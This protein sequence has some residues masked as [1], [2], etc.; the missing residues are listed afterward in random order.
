MCVMNVCQQ[1]VL[2]IVNGSG[3][4]VTHWSLQQ[5]F[6]QDWCPSKEPHLRAIKHLQIKLY[7]LLSVSMSISRG[8]DRENKIPKLLYM[9]WTKCSSS[10]FAILLVFSLLSEMHL[11]LSQKQMYF[12][13]WVNSS[14]NL[15]TCIYPA[16]T[17]RASE[18][19]WET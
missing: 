12:V 14:S 13:L 5:W 15:Y 9:D 7:P 8:E 17:V 2:T 19:G 3:S 1:L 4:P 11:D 16:L 6:H 18:R 10:S